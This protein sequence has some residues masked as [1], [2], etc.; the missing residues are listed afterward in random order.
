MFCVTS[1]DYFKNELKNLS[2]NYL[3]IGVFN[4]DSLSKLAREYP[5]KTIA[6]IDPFIEDGYTTIHTGKNVGDPLGEQKKNTLYTISRFQ[7]IKFFEMT[8]KEFYDNLTDDLVEELDISGVLIDG[9]HHYEHVKVDSLLA[10]RLIGNK[11]GHVMFDDINLED[12]QQ[13]MN[14]FRQTMYNRI[15]EERPMGDNQYLFVIKESHA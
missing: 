6:G 15:D 2:G 5:N 9:D 12:I 1:Y 13:V 10:I 3:E 7:N 14:E 4:G 8:S 11:K